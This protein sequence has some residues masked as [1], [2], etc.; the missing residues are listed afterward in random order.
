MEL[1]STVCCQGRDRCT[2]HQPIIITL[3]EVL[4]TAVHSANTWIVTLSKPY[5]LVLLPLA[6]AF[7]PEF[8]RT[9]WGYHYRMILM[10]AV[11]FS[12][13][14]FK[15]LSKQRVCGVVEQGKD[16]TGHPGTSCKGSR[17]RSAWRILL[18]R[19]HVVLTEDT[20]SSDNWD[21]GSIDILWHL[22]VRNPRFWANGFVH[23]EFPEQGKIITENTN[24]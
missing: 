14:P 7:D 23:W 18:P 17:G 6:E 22:L 4:R 16:V 8:A 1:I 24:V 12:F 20:F 9:L 5:V 2:C 11:F 19:G 21:R 13:L 15:A 10:A 3:C